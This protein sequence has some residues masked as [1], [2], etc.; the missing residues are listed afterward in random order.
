ML[1]IFVV[2]EV[3]RWGAPRRFKLGGRP[4]ER[5]NVHSAGER[6]KQLQH[7]AASIIGSP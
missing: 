4:P 2:E 1:Q 7:K 5:K 3:F 6:D